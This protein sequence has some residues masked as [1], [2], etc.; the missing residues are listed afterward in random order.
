[1]QKNIPLVKINFIYK[2]H[3]KKFLI[4]KNSKHSIG[5]ELSKFICYIDDFNLNDY[6][7]TEIENNKLSFNEFSLILELEKNNIVNEI[8][9]EDFDFDVTYILDFNHN[10]LTYIDNRNNLQTT[11]IFPFEII[12]CYPNT[13]KDCY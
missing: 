1:L 7:K 6:I 5:I 8:I 13:L 4:Q 10:F 2:Q 3:N 12:S 11:N 9:D